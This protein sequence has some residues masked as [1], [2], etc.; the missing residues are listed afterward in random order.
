MGRR[1][2]AGTVLAT[3]M[4][5]VTVPEAAAECFPFPETASSRLNVGYAFI[6]TG[7]RSR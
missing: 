4:L 7:R 5:A 2:A 6:A 1:M 3:L